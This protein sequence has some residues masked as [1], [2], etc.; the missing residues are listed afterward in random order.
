MY[1][2]HVT[3]HQQPRARRGP[4]GAGQLAFAQHVSS[5]PGGSFP[6]PGCT[7]APTRA[8]STCSPTATPRRHTST[9]RCSPGCAATPRLR[10]SPCAAGPWTS[11]W[12]TDSASTA[13]A[14]AGWGKDDM[15]TTELRGD[16]LASALRA[17][18]LLRGDVIDRDDP[19][20]DQAR[21]SGTV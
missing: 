8:A 2:L 10:N 17:E 12:S 19:G 11:G 1:A 4:A 14:A 3:S 20:Y 16:T 6:R 9:A 18:E 13:G 15:T 7:T 5:V 21:G